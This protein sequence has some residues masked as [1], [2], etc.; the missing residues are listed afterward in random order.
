MRQQEFERLYAGNAASL[1]NFLV[2]RTGD[3]HLAED[4]AAECFERV[5]RARRG[6]DRQKASERTWLYAIALNC[7][8]DHFRRQAAEQR[9]LQRA[10]PGAEAAAG[11]PALDRVEDRDLLNRA[12]A[13]LSTEEWEAIAIR[14]GGELTIAEIARLAGVP[15]TTIEGRIYGGLRKLRGELAGSPRE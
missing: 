3:R 4:L 7:L 1:L 9:A 10:E 8:R 15:Q 14:Y 12:L 6:F 13:I 2:F 11:D 5:L